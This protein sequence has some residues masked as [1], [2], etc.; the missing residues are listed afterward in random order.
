MKYYNYWTRIPVSLEVLFMVGAFLGV[1]S[2]KELEVI[3]DGVSFKNAPTAS[4]Y[5]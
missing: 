5:F 4:S 2:I 1:T 3:N